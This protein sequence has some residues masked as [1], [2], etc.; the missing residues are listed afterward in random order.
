MLT[1]IEASQRSIDAHCAMPSML[2]FV[3]Q[4][5]NAMEEKDSQIGL[6]SNTSVRPGP[7]ATFLRHCNNMESPPNPS[8]FPVGGPQPADDIRDLQQRCI[9][10]ELHWAPALCREASV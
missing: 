6:E 9:Y 8:I 3:V 4:G 10:G 5:L 1:N 7:I 2:H